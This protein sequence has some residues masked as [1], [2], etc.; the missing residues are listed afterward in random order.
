MINISCLKKKSECLNYP[1]LTELAYLH[2]KKDQLKR[3]N[4]KE[5]DYRGFK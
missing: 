3:V 4:L 2:I 1:S 5:R